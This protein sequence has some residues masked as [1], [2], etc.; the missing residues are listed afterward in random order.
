MIV[1]LGKVTKIIV[2]CHTNSELFFDD[3]KHRQR[4]DE[5]QRPFQRR[6]EPRPEALSL[7][8]GFRDGRG[9]D[10]GRVVAFYIDGVRPDYRLFLSVGRGVAV[11]GSGQ[12]S[13]LNHLHGVAP[14]IGLHS[15]GSHLAQRVAFHD[16]RLPVHRVARLP[17]PDF[18]F[19]TPD[20]CLLTPPTN[21]A[22]CASHCDQ[23]IFSP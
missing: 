12:V 13:D 3:V 14:F 22:A 15:D 5:R 21:N 20:A 4:H 9:G 6:A 17:T 8:R 16:H 11:T 2:N 18:R 1:F 23:A 10:G 7:I 19:L